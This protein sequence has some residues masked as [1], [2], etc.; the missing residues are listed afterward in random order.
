MTIEAA[1]TLWPCG[2]LCLEEVRHMGVKIASAVFGPVH[3]NVAPG[4]GTKSDIYDCYDLFT[5]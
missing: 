4:A 2:G 1:T 3:Q 5:K